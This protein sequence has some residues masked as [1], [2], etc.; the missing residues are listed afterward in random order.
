LKVLNIR[1]I[2]PFGFFVMTPHLNLWIDCM[3]RSLFCRCKSCHCI[4]GSLFF[5]AKIYSS[6]EFI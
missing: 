3:N 2:A 6:S 1:F 5:S 4:L